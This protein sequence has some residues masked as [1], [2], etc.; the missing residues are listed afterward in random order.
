LRWLGAGGHYTNRHNIAL[1]VVDAGNDAV[2]AIAESLVSAKAEL[3]AWE[4]AG[5]SAVFD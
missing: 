2:D 3:A 1:A 4:R 5:R